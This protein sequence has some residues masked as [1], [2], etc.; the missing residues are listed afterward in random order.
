MAIAKSTV[1]EN[2]YK[3]FYDL[4]NAI[5][6]FSNTV[7]PVF[8]EV[9]KDATADYPLVIIDSPDISWDT[10]TF[11]KNV[12]NG[13][14]DISVYTTVPKDTDQNT[15]KV[16]DKIE[17]SKSTLATAGLRQ[18]NLESTTSDMVPHGKIKVHIKT[19]TFVFKFYSNKTFAF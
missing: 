12:L 13:N 4:I 9:V 11:G 18:V 17:S 19:L 6:G 16:N 8:P 14:I 3:E 10:F 1:I 7:F 15:S 2:I 5:S